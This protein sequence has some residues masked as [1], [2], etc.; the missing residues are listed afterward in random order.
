GK[1]EHG[2]W[3]QT[4][5]GDVAARGE[6]ASDEQLADVCAVQTAI[7]GYGQPLAASFQRFTAHR[8]ADPGNQ[9]GAQ[10]TE[11]E[12]ADVIGAKNMAGEGFRGGQC[13]LNIQRIFLYYN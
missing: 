2:R 4:N 7:A 10:L 5:V 12:T 8:L 11:G 13:V 1:V 6:N 9:F 3:Y